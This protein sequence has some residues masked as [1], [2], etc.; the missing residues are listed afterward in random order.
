M[1]VGTIKNNFGETTN[2]I[3]GLQP[4]DILIAKKVV[5]STGDIGMS[6]KTYEYEAFIPGNEYK[7]H[8]LFDWDFK[9]IAYVADEDN[10]LHIVRP[11]VFDIKK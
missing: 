1:K 9:T 5:Y 2:V 4:G 7:V 11:E 3:L 8:H 6:G 10:S